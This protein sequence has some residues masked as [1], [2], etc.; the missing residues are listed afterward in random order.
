ML[1]NI[2]F[3]TDC[4]IC[5]HASFSELPQLTQVYDSYALATVTAN[6]SCYDCC[7]YQLL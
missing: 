3:P 6:S 5:C 2:C 7:K 4:F 1:A